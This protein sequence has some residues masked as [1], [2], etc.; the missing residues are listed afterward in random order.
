MGRFGKA[1]KA[2]MTGSNQERSRKVLKDTGRYW[3]ILEDEE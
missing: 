3:K 2:R 1:G